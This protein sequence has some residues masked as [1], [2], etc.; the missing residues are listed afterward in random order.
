MFFPLIREKYPY[1]AIKQ[2]EIKVKRTS[3]IILI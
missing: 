1:K 2:R 3:V